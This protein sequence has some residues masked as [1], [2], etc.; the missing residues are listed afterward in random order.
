MSSDFIALALM[1][2]CGALGWLIRGQFSGRWRD[3]KSQRLNQD[4]RHYHV[5]IDG[6]MCALTIEQIE[7]AKRRYLSLVNNGQV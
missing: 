5:R 3:I 1:A 2:T 6:D 4:K 7:S